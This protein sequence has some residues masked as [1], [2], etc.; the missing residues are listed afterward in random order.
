MKLIKQWAARK[1]TL[2]TQAEAATTAKK[3][4][5]EQKQKMIKKEEERHWLNL[6]KLE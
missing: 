4:H 3:R 1:G 6:E 5:S 2:E